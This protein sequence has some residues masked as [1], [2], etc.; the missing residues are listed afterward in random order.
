MRVL[1]QK[2]KR[3][4]EQGKE[5]CCEEESIGDLGLEKLLQIINKSGEKKLLFF[6]IVFL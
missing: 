6:S 5:N 4:T 2:K 3:R 1:A